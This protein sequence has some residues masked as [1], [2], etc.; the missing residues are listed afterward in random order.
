MALVNWMEPRVSV[1]IPCHGQAHFLADAIESV[2]RQ[3][4]P[5]LDLVVV[6]DGSPDTALME[7]V[8]S[9]FMD[10]ITYLRQENG[11]VAVARNAG[12]SRC[13]GEYLIFLDS[14]DRLLPNAVADGAAALTARPERGLVWGL[15]HLVD[16]GGRRGRLDV[17]RIGAGE[18]Y[19]D[20][21]Q[22]NIVGPPVGVMRG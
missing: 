1:V 3:T 15:R 11:G 16:A 8:L 22:T 12:L 5:A 17:G 2:F 20:L 19:I 6:N 4:V 13:G 18:R 14:D 10:R 21:L 9:P 7:E